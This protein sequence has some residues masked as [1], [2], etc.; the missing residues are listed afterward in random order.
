MEQTNMVRSSVQM[1]C[2]LVVAWLMAGCGTFEFTGRVE[3]DPTPTTAMAAPATWTPTP[4]IETAVVELT[5]PTATPIPQEEA[6]APTVAPTVV[7]TGSE[8]AAS[9]GH[10]DVAAVLI[11][12]ADRTPVYSGPGTEYEQINALFGGL[13]FPVSG[14]SADG[15]WWR[16][17]SCYDDTDQPAPACWISA[18]PSVTQPAEPVPHGPPAAL[19]PPTVAH[20]PRRG[21]TNLV[22]FPG[23]FNLDNGATGGV[24]NAQCEFNLYVGETGSGLVTVEPIA[25]A[26]F[27][28]GGVFPQPPSQ[29]QCANSPHLRRNA[30]TIA[31]LASMYICYETGVGRYGYLRFTDMTEAPDYSVTFEW[32]TFDPE[33]PGDVERI[34]YENAQYGFRLSLRRKGEWPLHQ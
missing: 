29:E 18:D 15:N 13:V 2:W 7:P 17:T 21:A 20:E 28:F 26:R 32:Y 25:P 1:I 8:E 14:I 9:M 22:E 24:G 23:C 27:G 31:P 10:T 4:G 5:P 6:S 19:P 34:S 30:E 16:L 3:L 12:A 33:Q 11:T